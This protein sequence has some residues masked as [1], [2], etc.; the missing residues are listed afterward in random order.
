L[1]LK[2]NRGSIIVFNYR[3]LSF[4]STIAKIV[5]IPLPPAK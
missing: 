2:W 4:P 5:F 1:N 3:K